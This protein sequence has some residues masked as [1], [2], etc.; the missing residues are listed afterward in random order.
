M[1]LV[2]LFSASS[3]LRVDFS[4]ICRL[5]CWFKIF[6]NYKRSVKEQNNLGNAVQNNGIV[7]KY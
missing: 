5:T 2:K 4:F 6:L 3:I 1:S 7:D